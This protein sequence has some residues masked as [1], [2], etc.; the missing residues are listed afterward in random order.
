MCVEREE[1]LDEWRVV[2][3]VIKT[4]REYNLKMEMLFIDFQQVPDTIERQPCKGPVRA[5]GTSKA[6]KTCTNSDEKYKRWSM[7]Y[8]RRI[9]GFCSEL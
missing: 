4:V 2:E 6:N 1:M 7:Y 3:R 9:S 8:G 5:K